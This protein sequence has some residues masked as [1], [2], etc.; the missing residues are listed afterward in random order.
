MY[1]PIIKQKAIAMY[2]I[3]VA[4]IVKRSIALMLSED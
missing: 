4:N 1:K 3:K 2:P